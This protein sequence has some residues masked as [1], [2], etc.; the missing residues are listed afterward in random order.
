MF[1]EAGDF[2]G[3]VLLVV[4]PTLL[5]VIRHDIHVMLILEHIACLHVHGHDQSKRRRRKGDL[6]AVTELRSLACEPEQ[7]YVMCIR[8]GSEF[9]DSKN[10]VMNA[11]SR[12]A[13]IL[14]MKKHNQALVQQ[15][16]SDAECVTI[17]NGIV[18]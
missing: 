12:I 2:H 3:E 5:V 14:K 10:S 15:K 6:L 7:W 17:Q 18:I 8:P 9:W 13:G 1:A 11:L 16:D 4:S